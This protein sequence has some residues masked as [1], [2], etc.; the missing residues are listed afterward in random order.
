[1]LDKEQ[2]LHPELALKAEQFSGQACAQSFVRRSTV[3]EKEAPRCALQLS[4]ALFLSGGSPGCIG[5]AQF[6]IRALWDMQ[7]WHTICTMHKLSWQH[8]KTHRLKLPRSSLLLWTVASLRLIQ[9]QKHDTEPASAQMQNQI[10]CYEQPKTSASKEILGFP[11]Q[12]LC[13][14]SPFLLQGICSPSHVYGSLHYTNLSYRH[15]ALLNLTKAL[16]LF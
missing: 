2:P 9:T 10:L 13:A 7:T 15:M 8:V 11:A 4:Q 14:H 3:H 1:M 6:P 12:Q 16:A 5:H